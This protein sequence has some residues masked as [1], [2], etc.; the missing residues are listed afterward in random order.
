[1]ND[2]EEIHVWC[3]LIEE[4]LADSSASSWA[5]A[6]AVPISRVRL[7]LDS[8]EALRQA[9]RLAELIGRVES[10]QILTR[11]ELVAVSDERRNLAIHARAIAGYGMTEA[12]RPVERLLRMMWVG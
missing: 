7:P 8:E 5:R 11:D 4:A 12:P 6:A 9:E 10:E 3:D 1:M 2:T